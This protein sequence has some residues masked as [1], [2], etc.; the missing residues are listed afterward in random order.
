ML[1]TERADY[2]DFNHLRPWQAAAIADGVAVDDA[3]G[4]NDVVILPDLS[5]YDRPLD[6]APGPLAWVNAFFGQQ[7]APVGEATATLEWDSGRTFRAGG[8]NDRVWGGD[9]ADA[10]DGG[11]GDDRIAGQG[12]RDALTGGDGN[13]VIFGDGIGAADG[14]APHNPGIPSLPL[15]GDAPGEA[16]HFLPLIPP[17]LSFLDRLF[18]FRGPSAIG[19]GND[20]IT[21]GAGDDTLVGGGGDDLFVFGI[22]AGHDTVADFAGGTASGDQLKIVGFA[23][24][25]YAEALAAATQRGSDTV[26]TLDQNTSITLTDVS[27]G[28]LHQHDFLFA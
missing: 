5:N 14:R 8:G 11:Q 25:T 28:S 16:S 4:G 22:G 17:L 2:V 15:L 24:D 9:G 19:S 20:T 27:V 12:A 7:P 6:P 13:D 1:F 21:G 18:E 26:I 23:V 3:L 10:I